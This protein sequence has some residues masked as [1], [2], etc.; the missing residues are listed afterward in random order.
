MEPQPENVQ[1]WN[2]NTTLS[3]K[4]SLCIKFML[5]FQISCKYKFRE[6]KLNILMMSVFDLH[7]K[8]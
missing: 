5:F 7:Y 2:I 3:K 4:L 6:K 1:N 8:I